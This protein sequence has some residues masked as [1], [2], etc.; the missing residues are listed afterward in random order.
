MIDKPISKQCFMDCLVANSSDFSHNEWKLFAYDTNE[1]LFS[2]NKIC[3]FYI[4]FTISTLRKPTFSIVW[5]IAWI[6]VSFEESKAEG[7]LSSWIQVTGF[8]IK[9]MIEYPPSPVIAPWSL[10]RSYRLFVCLGRKIRR[11]FRSFIIMPVI[12]WQGQKK[13]RAI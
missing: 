6:I 2:F 3:I 13:S 9:D 10:S 4:N 5:I 12:N 8:L 1:L 7:T 11:K